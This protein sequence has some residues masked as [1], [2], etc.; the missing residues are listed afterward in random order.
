[1][2]EYSPVIQQMK[3]LKQEVDILRLDLIHPLYGGN[4]F[5]KLKYNYQKAKEQGFDRVLTFGG[6]HS[7]HIFS[8][9]AFCAEMKIKCTG[10]I[11]GEKEMLSR[12]NVLQFAQKSGM[13]LHFVSRQDYSIKHE[14]FFISDL[15]TKFGDFYMIPEGG[16]NEEGVK[17]CMEILT[18]DLKKYD[19]VFCACGTAATFSGLKISAKESQKVV[20]ISVLK[21][22]NTLI[23]ESNKWFE[24]FNSSL[25]NKSDSEI[26]QSSTIIDEYHFGGYA[27]HTEEL[28]DFKVQ[29][30]NWFG[31]NLDYVYTSKVFAAVFDLIEKMKLLPHSSVLLVHTGGLHG[32]Q[33]YESRYGL[34]PVL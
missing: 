17:G 10:V 26:I 12:S 34:R 23:A 28:L 6:A 1:M 30:E 4:K 2:I 21:G 15:K 13:E 19:Y 31:V 14:T 29:F 11:R 33:S 32:N 3:Y 18:Q 24:K 7:N 20:G 5:F 22:E 25:I 9:A 16:N 8:T 27:K